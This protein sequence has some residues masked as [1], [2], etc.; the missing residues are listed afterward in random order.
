VTYETGGFNIK[1]DGIM[2]EM[3]REK[4][5]STAVAAFMKV[6]KLKLQFSLVYCQLINFIFKVVDKLKAANVEVVG[7]MAMVRNI[8]L[9]FSI[10][11][12]NGAVALFPFG[13]RWIF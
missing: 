10:E 8:F 11:L 13:Y 4:C 5:G 7:A 12:M 9:V 2:A 3:H 1:S 6:Y